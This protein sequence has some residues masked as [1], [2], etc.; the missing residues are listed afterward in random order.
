MEHT[1]AVIEGRPAGSRSGSPSPAETLAQ[2]VSSRMT[3]ADIEIVHHAGVA[4]VGEADWGRL[5]PDEAEGFRYYSAIEGA[6]PPGFRFEAVSARWR[7]RVVAAAPVFHVTYR[8]D[9]PLQGRWRPVGDWLYRSAPRLV[10]I[11]VMGLGSP[12][13]DRCHLG[14]DAELTAA[15]RGEVMAALLAGLDRKAAADRIPLLAIKDLAG[16]EA[17]PL[18]GAIADAGFSRIASLPVCVLDLPFKSEADYIQSLSANNRSVLRRKL[19]AAAKV[20]VET[21]RSIAGLEQ[22]I[23]ELYE[24]T[25]K[26][27]RFDYGDFEQLSPDYFRR[28]MDGLGERAAC[29]L[30]RVEGRL[31]AVKLM[32]VEKDRIIDKFWGMR[33]PIGRDY[34]LFFVAWMEGVRFAL[35]H[36]ATKFQSGQ[37]AYAQKVKLG[38]RLDPMWVYFRHRGRIT[39]RV[40]RTFAPLI[41]FDKMDPELGEIRKRE[42]ERAS[43]PPA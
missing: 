16:R 7:G 5:F 19:K 10:G 30:C 37:T 25:R 36:G 2:R 29:I 9:T 12:L 40:F 4:E 22:E 34:N 20:Q 18:A 11:P 39:N 15:E 14:F 33:Y 26:N 21:V 31:L 27:S 42:R 35:R 8:L 43:T 17:E 41:A 24:E 38:S 13:A 32:F 1:P 6:P 28:V 23:F 3:A